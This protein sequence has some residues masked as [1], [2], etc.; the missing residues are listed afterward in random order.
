VEVRLPFGFS[1]E[2]DALH[3]GSLYSS[4][5]NG[6]STWQFPLMAKYRIL[7]GAVQPYILGGVSFN[8]ITNVSDLIA[9]K[10][11][12]TSGIVLGGGVEVHL[13]SLKLSPELRYNNWTDKSFNISA[14][15]SNQNQLALLVGLTF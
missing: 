2:L 8:R 14:L 7:P 6:G 3:A 13:G 10:N 11:R 5:L 12:S 9:L 4:V 1:A 15:Q